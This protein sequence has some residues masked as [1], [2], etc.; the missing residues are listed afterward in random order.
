MAEP[1]R[2]SLKY[3]TGTTLP[4]TLRRKSS[5]VKPATRLPC[6]SV[7]TTST[8]T[9]RTSICSPKTLCGAFA[10]LAGGAWAP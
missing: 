1:P 2:T 6:L 8:L 9:T 7:T 3:S 10:G 4:S 5:G